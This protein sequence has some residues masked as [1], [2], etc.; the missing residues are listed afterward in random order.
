M[1]V[2]DRG[3]ERVA[4]H[5]FADGRKWNATTRTQHRDKIRSHGRCG[6]RPSRLLALFLV[7]ASAG[8]I[9]AQSQSPPASAAVVYDG[10]RLIVGDGSAIESGAFVVQNGRITAVGR[11]GEIAAPAG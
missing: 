8:S 1:M 2:S 11:K 6:M 9:T 10:A 3:P 5:L 4:L 7:V